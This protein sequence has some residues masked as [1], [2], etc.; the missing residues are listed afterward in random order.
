MQGQPDLPVH[1]RE[2]GGGRTRSTPRR[3]WT[4]SP[5]E[6]DFAQLARTSSQDDKAKDGGDWGFDDWTQLSTNEVAEIRKLAAGGISGKVDRP[7]EPPS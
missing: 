4:G 7:T 1:S 5:R 2:G 6:S 3:Y